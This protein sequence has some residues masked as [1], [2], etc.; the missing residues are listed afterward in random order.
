MLVETG[1][2]P[3]DRED[4]QKELLMVV[5][6]ARNLFAHR[7]DIYARPEDAIMLLAGALKLASIYMKW[8]VDE[9]RLQ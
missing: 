5:R 3:K 6:T 8:E 9:K 1:L 4:E 2:I 7:V